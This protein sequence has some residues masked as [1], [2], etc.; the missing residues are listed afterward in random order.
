M[1]GGSSRVTQHVSFHTEAVEP[2]VSFRKEIVALFG[3]PV[4]EN[5]T[6]VMME[7]AFSSLGL[8]WRYVTLEVRPE[9]LAAAV[10]G[11]VAM[12]F[13]GFNCTIPHK[14]AV[15]HLLDELAPS[16]E[17]MGAVNCV[18]ADEG[19]LIGH[20][21]DGQGL[22][23]LLADKRPLRGLRA[24]IIGAGGA[25][26]AIAVELILAGVRDLTIINRSERSGSNFA[27]LLLTRVA[28]KVGG[29]LRVHVVPLGTKDSA[30]GATDILVNAT[31]VGL[32]P[33]V[34]ARLPIDLVDLHADTLV[35]DVIPNPPDTHLIRTARANGCQVVDGLEML[36][37]QGRVGVELWSGSSPDT[38]VMHAA[39][40]TVFKFSRT[41]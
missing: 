3:R 19:R 23:A 15:V 36:V 9:N 1:T 2:M 10:D 24:T 28:D 30:L 14:Q 4:E 37:A 32:A 18:V 22:V 39:L 11:A 26:R 21:T 41:P 34:E 35:A 6:C 31:S 13:R 5:P 40:S 29:G 20:N 33:A 17:L 8:D 25:A 12:G 38:A 27:N 7:A 16:A